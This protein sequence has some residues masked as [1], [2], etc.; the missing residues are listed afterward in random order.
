VSAG[1]RRRFSW[2]AFV[3]VLLVLSPFSL[4]WVAERH[5]RYKAGP[6]FANWYGRM[7]DPLFYGIIVGLPLA[8]AYASG[9]LVGR[10]GWRGALPS[11]V[12]TAATAI[13]LHGAV[14]L[15]DSLNYNAGG[16]DQRVCRVHLGQLALA[17]LEYAADHGGALPPGG[18]TPE[19]MRGDGERD[20]HGEYVP[21]RDGYVLSDTYWRC[22]ADGV[23]PGAAP[24]E[25]RREMYETAA[26]A[27]AGPSYGVWQELC[28][29]DI[30]DLAQ[31]AS[32]PLIFDATERCAGAEDAFFRHPRLILGFIRGESGLNVAF[33]DGH[34]AWVSRSE[35]RRR[36]GGADRGR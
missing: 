28:G 27:I 35:W 21:A 32:T 11:A 24:L 2:R 7:P 19:A 18:A 22:P 30:G 26:Q 17:H 33:A 23:L 36:F 15:Y 13:S 1:D 25:R 4:H 34:V 31:P 29:A 3:L 6:G 20:R 10:Y 9:R 5:A 16:W 14:P 8:V 12:L